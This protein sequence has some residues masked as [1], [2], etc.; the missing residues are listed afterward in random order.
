[1]MGEKL[2]EHHVLRAHKLGMRGI[3][4]LTHT[5]IQAICFLLLLI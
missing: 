5:A 1:M 4:D 3:R 2:V